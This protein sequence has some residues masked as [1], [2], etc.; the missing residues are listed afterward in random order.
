MS[1]SKRSV[2]LVVKFNVSNF[3]TTLSTKREHLAKKIRYSNQTQPSFLFLFYFIFIIVGLYDQSFSRH[4]DILEILLLLSTHV[5][6][7]VIC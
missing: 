5:A 6:L 1:G 7:L 3:L 2:G 4:R